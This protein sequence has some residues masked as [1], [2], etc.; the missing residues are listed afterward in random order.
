MIRTLVDEDRRLDTKRREAQVHLSWNLLQRLGQ[1][2]T[3]IVIGEVH[4]RAAHELELA[5]GATGCTQRGFQ[6]SDVLGSDLAQW[7]VTRAVPHETI[8]N[9]AVHALTTEPHGWTLRRP[10][11]GLEVD[12]VEG[13]ELTVV[14]HR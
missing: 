3:R 6:C 2:R 14:R 12:V 8:H 1:R 10:W 11:L 7:V 13:E 4:A 5:A 9:R